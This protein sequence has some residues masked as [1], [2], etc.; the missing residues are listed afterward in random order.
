VHAR[1]P[2]FAPLPDDDW[3][4]QVKRYQ[5]R[6]ADADVIQH[7]VENVD[8]SGQRCVV[9][10]FGFTS[11]ARALA[12]DCGVHLLEI[13]DFVPLVL[14]GSIR[15]EL[16]DRLGLPDWSAVGAAAEPVAERA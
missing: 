10:A 8:E 1:F 16:R 12:D 14:A 13:A 15:D 11:E 7:L 5:D 2:R 6:P 4:V 3:F 9:S